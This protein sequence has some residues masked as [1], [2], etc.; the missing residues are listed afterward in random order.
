MDLVHDRAPAA[1]EVV[2]RAGLVLV[3]GWFGLLKV[4]DASPVGAL[5]SAT[6]P[7]VEPHALLVGLG[8]VEVLLAL[9]LAVLRDSVL[10]PLLLVGHLVG[11]FLAFAM[12]PGIVF[13]DGNP[14]LVTTEGEFVLKNVVLIGALLTLVG[15][16]ARRHRVAV[17]GAGTAPGD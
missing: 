14:L 4:A 3:F 2:T 16:V 9:A 5:L 7:F 8:V 12:A 15:Q 6:I 13:R 1:G 17:D 10:V 11:T